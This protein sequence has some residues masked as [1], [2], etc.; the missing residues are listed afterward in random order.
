[1]NH[2]G[3]CVYDITSDLNRLSPHLNVNAC[4]PIQAIVYKT[5]SQSLRSVLRNFGRIRSGG[6]TPMKSALSRAYRWLANEERDH[7]RI[8]FLLTDGQPYDRQGT[9]DLI[10]DMIRD[11]IIVVGVGFGYGAESVKTLF[12]IAVWGQDI[13]AIPKEVIATLEPLIMKKSK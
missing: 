10:D 8:C 2:H 9:K 1:M 4:D 13:R 11:G 3:N 12:P 6:G 7:V 5:E